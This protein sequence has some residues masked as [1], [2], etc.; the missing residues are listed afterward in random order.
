M[1]VGRKGVRDMVVSEGWQLNLVEQID[2]FMKLSPN[3]LAMIQYGSAIDQRGLFDVWSD[4]DLLIVLKDGTLGE[5]FPSI[6]WTKPFGNLLA[7]EQYQNANNVLIRTCFNDLSRIDFV[8]TTESALLNIHD[9]GTTYLWKPPII[10]FSKSSIV[11]KTLMQ[12]VPCPQ[13]P[14]ISPEQFTDMI[15]HFWFRAATAVTKVVRND[16]LIA[17][18]LALESVQDCC[19]LEMLHRDR[20]EGTNHHRSGGTGNILVT[21]LQAN[22]L[23]YTNVGILD[24]IANCC[25]LFDTLAK[26]W[27]DTYYERSQ[28]ILKWIDQAKE[29]L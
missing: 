11:T 7:F 20:R 15:N 21:K 25:M 14:L 18:H 2:S 27:T 3:V 28:P 8:F 1:T 23:P 19:V 29:C 24:T 6:E 26:Q 9:W 10:R 22:Q 13:P 16:L 4:I 5:F 12:T 17:L